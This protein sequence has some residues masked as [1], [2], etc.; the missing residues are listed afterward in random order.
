MVLGHGLED[1]DGNR[2]E[3]TGLLALETSFA[4]GRLHLGYRRA[5]LRAACSLGAEG[6]EVLGHEFHYARTVSASGDP[7]V[8]CRDATGAEVPEQG[9][10]EGST[11]GTFFHVIDRVAP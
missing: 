6:T 4:K 3:M 11:T 1:A 9:A 10:R 7:L 2:H 5:R 8:D